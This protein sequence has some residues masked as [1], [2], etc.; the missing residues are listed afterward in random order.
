MIIGTNSYY[1]KTS[2]LHERDGHTITIGNNVAVGHWCYI[3]TRMHT[4]T[5]H[6]QYFSGDIVIEDNVWIGNNVVIYPNV[7]IGKGAVI[8]AGCVIT[9]NVAANTLV[10]V[11]MQEYEKP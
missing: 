9:K 8:G 6:T 11:M 1:N 3:S 7:T 5:D 4:T 2:M 10:K